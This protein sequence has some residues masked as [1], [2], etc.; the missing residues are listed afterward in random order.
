MTTGL[1]CIELS[2]QTA[3]FAVRE[4][5]TIDRE[6]LAERLARWAGLVRGCV[7]VRTCGRCEVYLVDSAAER[8]WPAR[9]AELVGVPVE[10]LRPDVRVSR[11]EAAAEHLLR[12]AAGL[13]SPILGETHVLGQVREAY[14]S[15]EA[16]RTAG[17]VLSALF[18]A[19]IHCG[20]RIRTETNIAQTVRSYAQVALDAVPE[21]LA[22]RKRALILGSGTLAFEVAERLAGLGHH[23][24]V[25]SRHEARGRRL[26]EQ[27]GAQWV[28]L[29]SI[30]AVLAT[31][32]VVVAC[33][34]SPRFVIKHEMLTEAAGPL[35]MVDLGM[36]RNID[37]R[38][39]SFPHV[40][41]VSL[42]QLTDGRELCGEAIAAA[43]AIVA[44]ELARFGRWLQARRLAQLT[45]RV[46][47]TAESWDH[48][49]ARGSRRSVQVGSRRLVDEE[50]A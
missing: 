28:Q 40:R 16:K 9:F 50:A 42:N 20:K 44:E 18:R 49:R 35:A 26:A 36:P 31:T 6:R 4:R 13:E 34:S 41:L 15:A 37:P 25:V 7:G 19:A 43:E 29:E 39:S 23:L 2:H 8:D 5:V 47:P 24:T 33:T 12:V 14:S 48:R 38:V 17:P 22:G 11:S 45:F 21:A 3:P 27:F 30:D 10:I 46:G 32:D 1:I